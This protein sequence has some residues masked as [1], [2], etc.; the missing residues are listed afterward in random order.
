MK[1]S[2]RNIEYSPGVII[3]LFTFILNLLVDISSY[4]R[5]YFA[6]I[7]IICKMLQKFILFCDI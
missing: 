6:A 5:N 4:G 2:S 1:H 3:L 7:G